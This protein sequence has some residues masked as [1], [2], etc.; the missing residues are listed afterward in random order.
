MVP[1]P[2]CYVTSSPNFA[3]DEMPR[4]VNR[5]APNSGQTGNRLARPRRNNLGDNEVMS[6]H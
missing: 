6:L 4:V 5:P 3:S 1:T 2:S